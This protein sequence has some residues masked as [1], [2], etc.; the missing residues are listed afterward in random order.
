MKRIDHRIDLQVSLLLAVFV[1]VVTMTCF[2]VSYRVT[3]SDMRHSLRER[4]EILYGYLEDQLDMSTFAD[5]DSREDVE[6]E[7]YLAMH[8]IFNAVKEATGVMY[9]YTAKK[10]DDGKY[11]YVIDCQDITSDDYRYPGDLIEEEIYQDMDRALGGEEV[12]PDEIVHTSWGNIFICYLPLMSDGEVVG[13]LGI[14][15]EAQHQYGTYQKLKMFVPMAVLAF[16]ILA[17]FVSRQMFEHVNVIV[18]QQA[19]QKQ[20]LE[21]ALQEAEVA[22]RA[23]TNFLFNMSHDIRTPMNAIIGFTQIARDSLDNRE[24][25]LDSLNKVERASQHLKR[26]INDVLN[27]AKIENGK[28]ELETAPCRLR[29]F[30]TETEALIRPDMEEKGLEF[31]VQMEFSDESP[32]LCDPLRIRQIEFNLLSNALKYTPKGGRVEYRVFQ[33][34]PDADGFVQV[35]MHIKDNGIGMS[36]EF[37]KHIFGAFEREKSATESRVEGTGLGLAITKRLVELHGGTIQVHSRQ[38]KGS[39]FIVSLRLETTQEP[40]PAREAVPDAGGIS[41]EEKRILVAEDNELNRE[42]AEV[43]LSERGFLVET[44]ADGAQAVEMVKKAGPGY[45]SLVLMDIQMPGMDG[46]QATREIRSLED[47]ALSR[48]PIVAMTANAFDEDRKRAFEC[49]MDGHIAKPIDIG[50]LERALAQVVIE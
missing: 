14:E 33:S 22:S 27:M 49:G 10:N 44:A 35:R 34:E 42:I 9:L 32:V 19:E 45:Y 6:R 50:Q 20:I 47:P 12:Y 2:F 5:I 18:E 23:K 17:F 3:Y 46:Y 4:V 11:I 26:L 29:D 48:I 8:R 28:L 40:C 39:E 31:T 16:T 36:E 15:F 25:V 38:G 1:A 37:Q 21:R 41:F 43:I 24:R 7:D 30:V 13:V